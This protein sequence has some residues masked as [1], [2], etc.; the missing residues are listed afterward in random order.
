MKLCPVCKSNF[1]VETSEQIFCGGGHCLEAFANRAMGTS[2]NSCPYCSQPVFVDAV[3]CAKCSG[4]LSIGSHLAIKHALAADPTLSLKDE[5][6]VKKLTALVVQIDASLQKEEDKVS[7][8][9]D[10]Q[11]LEDE[12]SWNKHLEEL[13]PFARFMEVNR[14][15]VVVS[16]VA[17]LS[18]VALT[19][20]YLS[21][22][23]SNSIENYCG[24]KFP[25]SSSFEV[26]LS[27][28]NETEQ[29]VEGQNLLIVGRDGT[30]LKSYGF[31]E[32]NGFCYGR[33]AKSKFS[34]STFDT[35]GPYAV[36]CSRF[37]QVVPLVHHGQ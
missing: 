7:A 19:V 6:T 36:G 29:F 23:E 24:D 18:T 14:R 4:I 3:V 10:A 27:G 26:C 20:A 16:L 12:R 9:N 32:A 2:I 5:A 25:E 30:P 28:Y 31:G 11:K 21:Y 33:H 8:E 13:S 17:V 15:K 35:Q 22:A 37:F 34:G 1:K